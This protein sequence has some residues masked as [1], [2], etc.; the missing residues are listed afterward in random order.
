MQL[1]RMLLALTAATTL[2]FSLVAQDRSYWIGNANSNDIMEVT[3][4][5]KVLQRFDV[6]GGPRQVKTDPV[7]G[8]TWVLIKSSSTILIYG[9]NGPVGA[10]IVFSQGTSTFDVAFD[11]QGD[12]WVTGANGVVQYDLIGTEIQAYPMTVPELRGI[13]ID[14]LGNKWIAHRE[15]LGSVTR[16]D[17]AGVVTN[18][19]VTGRRP[20]EIIADFRGVG[21]PSRIWVACADLG[22]ILELDEN[23]NELNKYA[24]AADVDGLVFDLNGDIWVRD[25]QLYQVN[26][27]TGAVINTYTVASPTDPSFTGISGIGIDTLGR[28]LVTQQL[29]FGPPQP[30][31]APPCEVQRIDPA[32]G[33]IEASTVLAFGGAEGWGTLQAPSTPF[34]YAMV[35]NPTGDADGDGDDNLTEIQNGTSPTDPSSSSRFSVDTTGNS[36]LG[37]TVSINVRQNAGVDVWVTAFANDVLA[38]PTPVPGFGGVM[39]IDPTTVALITAGTGTN[40]TPLTIPTTPNLIGSCLFIQGAYL[41]GSTFQLG[42]LSGVAIW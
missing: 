9:P 14:S 26:P 11:A 4:W 21:V 38:T 20:T 25:T 24:I 36:G 40:S 18:F 34:Q 33:T 10:P 22:E 16:I 17:P 28:I 3:P 8:L 35:V 37:G 32:T 31:P 29:N 5:G 15:F 2:T 42:N 6:G 1:P 7:S 13:T 41:N 27:A 12:V 23:G 19:P 30:Q 39:Q